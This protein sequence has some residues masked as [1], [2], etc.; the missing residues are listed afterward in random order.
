MMVLNMRKTPLLMLATALS[1]TNLSYGETLLANEDTEQTR[2]EKSV[3]VPAHIIPTRDVNVS[4]AKIYPTQGPIH[5]KGTR[6]DSY[7]DFGVR[8]DELV[9]MA[10]LDL[11]F[12]PSPSLLPIESQLKVFL[13]DELMGVVA[14]KKEDLGVKTLA[15]LPIDPRFIK[16]FNQVRM[17]FI[18]HYRDICE[19]PTNSTLWLDVSQNSNLSMQVQPLV[20]KNDLSRFPVPFFDAR[21]PE[22]LTLP[23]VFSQ[24]ASTKQQNAAAILA[25]WFGSKAQWRDQNYPVFMDTLPKQ[26]SIVFMTNEHR[27]R[28]L[29]DYPVVKG[30][31]IEMIS[32]PDDP[33][34][35]LL[36]IQGRN[37]DDLIQAVKGISQGEL[38]LR[39]AAV[40]VENVETLAPRVPYDAPNWVKTDKP[41]SFAELVTYKGQLQS[42][43]LNPKPINLELN[44]PPDLFT[45]RNSGIEMQLNYRYTAPNIED[46]S[47]MMV[48]L[49]NELIQSQSLVPNKKESSLLARLPFTQSLFDP[50]S[51]LAV[52]A[53]KLGQRNQ[54]QFSFNYANPIPGGTVDQCITYQPVNNTVVIDE[55]STI[56]FSGYRHYMAMPSLQAF[57]KSG[58][59]FSRMA[60][61][62]ETVVLM[63][64]NASAEH[65]TTLLN[66]MG[67][68]GAQTGFPAINV[69]LTNALNEAKDAN[70]DLLFIGEM[71][72]ALT[73]N[74]N[75]QELLLEKTK[76]WIKMPMRPA[77]LDSKA[78]SAADSAVSSKTTVNSQGNIAAIVEFQSPYNDQRSVVALL[79][80]SSKGFSLLNSAITD[81]GKRNFMSGSVSVIRDSGINSVQVG[82]I[83]YVGYLPWWEKVWSIFA[84][85]PI[86]LTLLTVAIVVIFGLLLWRLMKSISRRRLLSE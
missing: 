70:A 84:S 15:S 5:L 67:M 23:I 25:S 45:F 17:E 20:L 48:N 32:H 11:E 78:L 66:T 60:D 72:N 36:L 14:I 8:S 52:P 24:S 85:H 69:T 38:L 26:H 28:F 31:M 9:S 76:S 37:D 68:I 46:G 19:N 81:S 18:G 21:D 82:D 62:S 1:M 6:P 86:L 55:N 77:Y 42:S 35:K 64:E 40:S 30:P 44:L 2:I 61:L 22:A 58:F 12:T 49:N 50:D 7:I 57:S 65:I 3:N 51:Q 16:D 79:A 73:D 74:E 10:R 54:L 29:A 47:K 4:F 27:P 43:G 39:G 59:P 83:Y 33:S 41:V 63:P 34:I 75:N 13:N 53:L 80:D 56:D 71:S